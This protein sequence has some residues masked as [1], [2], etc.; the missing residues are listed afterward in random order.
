MKEPKHRIRTRLVSAVLVLGLSC[1]FAANSDNPYTPDG[2]KRLLEF[3][4]WPRQEK[5]LIPEFSLKNS[6]K[7]TS[8]KIDKNNKWRIDETLRGVSSIRVYPTVLAAH[9]SIINKMCRSNIAYE[10]RTINDIGDVAF[11]S[12]MNGI[13]WFARKNVVVRI[14]VDTKGFA[15]QSEFEKKKT[16]KT[17]EYFAARID[18]LI[19]KVPRVP[20]PDKMPKLKASPLLK[21]AAVQERD[22]RGKKQVILEIQNNEAVNGPLYCEID[23]TSRPFSCINLFRNIQNAPE[24]RWKYKLVSGRKGTFPFRVVFITS[25]NLVHT[26]ETEITF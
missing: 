20:D 13:Y 5:N 14:T 12:H 4:K 24:N 19:V 9:D 22:K 23:C 18:N 26:V 25:G 15:G 7:D 3:A 21:F 8:V 11:Y 2:R 6:W 1:A 10:G 17:V 16:F